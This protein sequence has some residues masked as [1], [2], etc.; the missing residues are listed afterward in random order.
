M[1]KKAGAGRSRS[2]DGDRVKGSENE[3]LFSG[4]LDRDL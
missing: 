1:G 4:D 3:M 2:G